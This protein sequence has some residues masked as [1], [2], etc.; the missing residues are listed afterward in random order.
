MGKIVLKGIDDEEESME[1]QIKK[2]VEREKELFDTIRDKSIQEEIEGEIQKIRN[3]EK[4]KR[5]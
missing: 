5:L 4:K 3:S 2:A 1:Q